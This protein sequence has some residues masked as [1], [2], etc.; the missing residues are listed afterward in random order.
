[1]LAGAYVCL[2]VCVCVRV[3][4]CVCS[5]ITLHAANYYGC[6]CILQSDNELAILCI[7]I[8][9]KCILLFFNTVYV[10]GGGTGKR[11]E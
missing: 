4:V 11:K 3:R 5:T 10:V 7:S 1:M 9:G 8:N 2:F 6:I